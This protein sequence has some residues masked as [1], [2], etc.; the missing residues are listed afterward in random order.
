MHLPCVIVED[1]NMTPAQLV[2]TQ[3][4]EHIRGH[5]VTPQETCSTCSN[6]GRM[7]DVAVISLVL[8]RNVELTL[9]LDA[10]FAPRSSICCT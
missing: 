2:S 10:P 7:I 6:G 8:V 5:I 9:D 1:F 3:W 4:I